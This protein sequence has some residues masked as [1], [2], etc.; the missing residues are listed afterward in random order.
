MED[1][2]KDPKIAGPPNPRDTIAIKGVTMFQESLV[3]TWTSSDC[4]LPTVMQLTTKNALGG[5]AIFLLAMLTDIQGCAT[6]TEGER[7]QIEYDLNDARAV[8]EERRRACLQSGAYMFTET[9]TG[10]R[11]FTISEMKWSYCR[12]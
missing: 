4:C 6:L 8:Y 3:Q 7:E 1:L 12:Q 10:S 9:L 11:R 2:P 5:L